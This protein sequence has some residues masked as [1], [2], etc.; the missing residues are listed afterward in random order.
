MEYIN[1]EIELGASDGPYWARAASPFR[2]VVRQPF[3]LPWKDDADLEAA[4]DKVELAILR[5]SGRRRRVG[6]GEENVL[7]QFG[8]GLFEAAISGEI[9]EL[10]YDARGRALALHKGLR[11][12]LEIQPGVAASLPWELLFDPRESDFVALSEATPIVRHLGVG[13]PIPPMRLDPPLR[14]LGVIADPSDLPRLD[15]ESERRRVDRA[16]ESL[17]SIGLVEIE[18]L[19]Y[20]T[21]RELQAV[22]RRGPWHVLHFVGHGEFNVGRSEGALALIDE[23]GRSFSLPAVQLSRLVGDHQSLRLIV[24][25]ACEGAKGDQH[26]AF[27]STAATLVKRGTPAVLAMQYEISDRAAIELARSFYSALFDGQ[28]VD[29]AVA[30]A[31]VGVSIAVPHSLEWATPVLFMRA[32]DGAMFDLAPKNA[33]GAPPNGPRIDNAREARRPRP[34]PRYLSDID[35]L[36]GGPPVADRRPFRGGRS[37]LDRHVPHL[38]LLLSLAGATASALAFFGWPTNYDYALQLE[39]RSPGSYI[40]L[41]AAAT[42]VLGIGYGLVMLGPTQSASSRRGSSVLRVAFVGLTTGVAVAAA[43]YPEFQDLGTAWAVS[44]SCLAVLTVLVVL[45]AMEFRDAALLASS[46]VIA[47]SAVLP[48]QLD[49]G[50]VS[51]IEVG[52]SGWIVLLVGS[53][54]VA[55]WVKD[56]AMSRYGVLAVVALLMAASSSG[57]GML[58]GVPLAAIAGLL[59]LAS[60][61]VANEPEPIDPSI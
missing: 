1:F 47:M 60:V 52:W 30:Q 50:E 40:A 29:G 37:T 53:L 36:F 56:G 25:N 32:V 39:S 2:D 5:G 34:G 54:S 51:G 4:L 6:S 13:K 20:S 43:A 46:A 21:W 41:L 11:I 57:D 18:W 38:V 31:R 22:M 10:Y 58:F 59:A 28:P 55:N 17:T 44:V 35:R 8:R 16:L 12:R 61:L 3:Q 26:D 19:E 45:D 27:S 15:V 42:A 23:V 9:R 49:G 33:P 14:I 24:L 48:W 7:R